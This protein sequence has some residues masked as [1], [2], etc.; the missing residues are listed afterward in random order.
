M[1]VPMSTFFVTGGY[2]YC[3]PGDVAILRSTLSGVLKLRPDSRFI[4]W[5]DRPDAQSVLQELY[6]QDEVFFFSMSLLNPGSSKGAPAFA[7]RLLRQLYQLMFGAIPFVLCSVFG[8][9]KATVR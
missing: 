1:E 5:N 4:I 6:P 8:F 2:T 9:G 3:N 7:K